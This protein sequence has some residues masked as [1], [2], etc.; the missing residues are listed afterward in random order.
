[1]YRIALN[2]GLP[3]HDTSNVFDGSIAPYFI[4]VAHLNEAGNHRLAERVSE[5]AAAR[6]P[7]ALHVSR[8]Q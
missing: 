5:I 7:T 6:M 1:M 8:P 3:V 2:S 4:D